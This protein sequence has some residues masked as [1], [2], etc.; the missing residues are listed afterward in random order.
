MTAGEWNAAYPIGTHVRVVLADGVAV[1]T[2]T[3]SEAVTWG[4]LCHI[5]VEGLTGYVVLN[6]VQPLVP[7]LTGS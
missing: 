4:E 1:T 2:R 3:A 7:P 5:Q 6:W